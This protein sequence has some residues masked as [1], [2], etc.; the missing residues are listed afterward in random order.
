[1][2]EKYDPHVPGGLPGPTVRAPLK[3]ELDLVSARCEELER[4]LAEAQA[5]LA[6]RVKGGCN[7]PDGE[8][9]HLP[10]DP[11][12]ARAL[13]A[14]RQ[15]AEAKAAVEYF[16]AHGMADVRALWANGRV[17]VSCSHALCVFFR[18]ALGERDALKATLSDTRERASMFYNKVHEALGTDGATVNAPER[19]MALK[20]KLEQAQAG[21]AVRL[22]MLE[23]NARLMTT[24]AQAREVLRALISQRGYVLPVDLYKQVI[25]A[26]E[27]GKEAIM[28]WKTKCGCPEQYHG[29][30]CPACH[31]TGEI[32][33]APHAPT[34][35][36]PDRCRPGK[37]AE[38]P[39][40][41]YH[42][43]LACGLTTQSGPCEH[44][45]ASAVLTVRKP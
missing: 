36:C 22:V 23:E 45:G 1:M 29:R 20:A 9:T 40:V 4:E 34:P 42:A 14:E 41:S 44:C 24:L 16:T 21:L 8:C 5:A 10:T 33:P 26:L 25:T 32:P 31:G 35:E 30:W 6:V 28:P 39:P 13:L 3:F 2:R 27:G 15:L 43:C 11:W 7:C 12:V 17:C 38:S 19:I 37:E 18:E